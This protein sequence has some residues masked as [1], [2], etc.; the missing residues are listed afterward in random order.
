[1]TS[2]E[3]RTLL[4]GQVNWIMETH[5]RVSDL[6]HGDDTRLLKRVFLLS[7]MLHCVNS[8]CSLPLHLVL[9]D[10]VAS[11]SGSAELPSILNRLGATSSRDTLE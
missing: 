5:L 2:T 11:Y 1:M 8:H 3:R 6:L 9:A 10:V 4:S 7:V